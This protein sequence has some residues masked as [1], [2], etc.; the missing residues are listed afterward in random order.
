VEAVDSRR[1]PPQR[2]GPTLCDVVF[3]GAQALV[4]A[5]ER[6]TGTGQIDHPQITHRLDPR[7]TPLAEG[8]RRDGPVGRLSVRFD[9][10]A[11]VIGG[12]VQHA[13]LAAWRIEAIA[14]CSAPESGVQR[15]PM[16]PHQGDTQR[17]DRQILV[18]ETRQRRR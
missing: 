8:A 15:E 18:L 5:N 14:S 13:E 4:R 6:E 2:E 16:D 10:R 3:A 7:P 12:R 9:E 17:E 11:M 1:V